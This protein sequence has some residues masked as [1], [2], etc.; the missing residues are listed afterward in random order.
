MITVYCSSGKR[1]HVIDD[2]VFEHLTAREILDIYHWSY[3]SNAWRFSVYPKRIV[4]TVGDPEAEHHLFLSP[5]SDVSK[6]KKVWYKMYCETH[7]YILIEDHTTLLKLSRIVMNSDR[8]MLRA[9]LL[10]QSH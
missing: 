8:A 7:G 6:L 3:G 2:S 9:Y 10:L 4:Y 5:D 1:S